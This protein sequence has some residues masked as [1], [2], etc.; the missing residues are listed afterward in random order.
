MSSPFPRVYEG[1]SG[2]LVDGTQPPYYPA[3]ATA[4]DIAAAVATQATAD[5]GTYVRGLTIMPSDDATGVTDWTNIQAALTVARL[6]NRTAGSRVRLIA[7]ASASQFAVNQSLIIGSN[8]TLDVDPGVVL[9]LAANTQCPILVSYASGIGGGPSQAK[10]GVGTTA[11]STSVTFS[12]TSPQQGSTAFN[13]FTGSQPCSIY[14]HD[15]SVFTT[16]CTYVDPTH[17]TLAA[18]PTVTS[19]SVF[20]EIGPRDTN[21]RLDRLSVLRPAYITGAE[22]WQ[23]HSVM[24]LRVD[25]LKLNDCAGQTLGGLYCYQIGAVTKLRVRDLDF[26]KGT[27]RDG[28]HLNGPLDDALIEGVTTG[29]GSAQTGDDSCPIIPW[30]GYTDGLTGGAVTNVTYRKCNPKSATG[31]FTIWATDA[32]YAGNP[33]S[34]ASVAWCDNIT[35]EDCTGLVNILNG[36]TMPLRVGA[37]RFR[38]HVGQV[39]VAPNE[40]RGTI[41]LIDI[42]G[43][44]LPT[45][46]ANIPVV[47][48]KGGTAGNALTLDKLIISRVNGKT[49]AN[50]NR[51]VA[52]NG[53]AMTVNLVDINRADIDASGFNDCDLVG[54]LTAGST[55]GTLKVSRTHHKCIPGINGQLLNHNAGGTVGRVFLSDVEH[56]GYALAVTRAADIYYSNVRVNAPYGI[57]AVAAVTVRGNGWHAAYSG[58]VTNTMTVAGSQVIAD[59]PIDLTNLAKNNGDRAIN[60]QA[61]LACG[62]GPAVSNGTNWKNIYSGAVY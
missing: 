60:T 49:S 48:L 55:I 58:G 6:A 36:L 7:S 29:S 54:V 39:T 19:V 5:A 16:T 62:V 13:T 33:Q 23:R 46:A 42:N 14:H 30:V 34:A 51:L 41:D 35:Y 56:D 8:T 47:N 38:D 3:P 31:P 28:L 18:A 4:A 17:I 61:S 32:S 40:E 53:A 44:T 20:I 12:S 52:V 21:I 22:T 37:I 45:L 2:Y 59:L 26:S 24:L 57:Y 15:G 27:V 43:F 11:R 10:I 25:G 50:Q 9:T 1:G